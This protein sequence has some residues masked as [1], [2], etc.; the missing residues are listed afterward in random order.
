M[1]STPNPQERSFNC[2]AT[3]SA[4]ISRQIRNV[5]QESELNFRQFLFRCWYYFRIGY[6]TYLTFLLGF[7]T[8]LVTVYYLAINNIPALKP[9]Q[10]KPITLWN[11][12][13]LA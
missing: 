13:E 4:I 11:S 9:I 10:I 2:R 12:L 6:S 1:N 7:A 5:A 3:R 8:T